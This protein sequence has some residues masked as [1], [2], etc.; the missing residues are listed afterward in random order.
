MDDRV[1]VETVVV[2]GFYMNALVLGCRRTRQAAIIDPGDAPE[3]LLAVAAREGLT[4]THIL[5][6]HGHI[7]HVAAVG[8]V[9]AATG[10]PIHLH[11][12]DRPLYDRVADQAR[13]FGLPFTQRMPPIDVALADGDTLTIGELAVRVLHTPGHSPGSVCFHVGLGHGL[14]VAG[15]V[16]FAG[17]IGRTDLWGG[18]FPALLRSIE[19]KLFPLGDETAVHSGH[20]PV[21]TIGEERRTNPFL[22]DIG[23]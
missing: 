12:D 14:V 4:V 1:F 9:Q 17:S 10:A 3:R 6:T 5:L 2:S 16:L 18:S 7:D 20:G 22:R 19:T 21:T 15:D 11:P 23:R 13:A 8:E